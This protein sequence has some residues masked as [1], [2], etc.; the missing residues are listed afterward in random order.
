MGS[1]ENL[2]HVKISLDLELIANFQLLKLLKEFKDIFAWTYKD[3]KGIPPNIVQHWIELDTSMP[4]AHQTRYQLNPNYATIIKHDIDKLLTACFIKPTAEATRLSPII[5][6]PKRNG[7]LR[8]CVDFIK[9][10]VI[11]KK[12]PD[13]LPF[14]NEVINMVVGHEVY[15]F[16]DGF[17]KY[18]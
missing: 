18:H 1:E 3:L 7:Q 16:I 15:T 4:P 10:N 14:T 8:I 2:Q 11:T 13:L 9:I 12:D 5:V 6:V 17:S